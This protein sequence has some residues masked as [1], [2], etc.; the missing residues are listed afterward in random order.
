[1]LSSE[2]DAAPN[3]FRFLNHA[4]NLLDEGNLARAAGVYPRL[5]SDAGIMPTLGNC[6]HCRRS[7]ADGLKGSL[8]SGKG[9]VCVNCTRPT[10]WI[11]PDAIRV[12]QGEWCEDT[13]VADEV[14]TTLSHWLQGELGRP[15]KVIRI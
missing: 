9:F 11:S 2:Q 14:E 7:L 15:L 4:L 10:R 8:I 1:M 5:L 12:L 6:V 13:E 3:L